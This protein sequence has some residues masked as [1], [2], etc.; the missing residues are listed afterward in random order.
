MAS[1]DDSIPEIDLS[2][3]VVQ[4]Y[5]FEPLTSDSSEEPNEN[6]E[7]SGSEDSENQDSDPD[8]HV[9]NKSVIDVKTDRIGNTNWL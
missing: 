3:T 7:G 8:V 1:D 9:T 6:S 5:Q 2:I 4:P